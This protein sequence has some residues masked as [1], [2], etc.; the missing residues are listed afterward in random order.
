MYAGPY[1]A[2]MPYE[3]IAHDLWM[4]ILLPHCQ[5]KVPV[6]VLLIND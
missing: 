6:L 4:A 5:E 1:K 2:C 3:E